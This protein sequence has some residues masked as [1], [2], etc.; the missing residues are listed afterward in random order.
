MK[1]KVA[2]NSEGQGDLV[3]GRGASVYFQLQIGKMSS[4]IYWS[5]IKISMTNNNS[6]IQSYLQFRN[7]GRNPEYPTYTWMGKTCTEYR[8]QL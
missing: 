6:Q 5:I 4:T 7:C 2:C 1:H 3:V 8:M